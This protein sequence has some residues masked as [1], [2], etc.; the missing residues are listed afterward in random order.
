LTKLKFPDKYLPD[1]YLTER[2]LY[3]IFGIVFLFIIGF[4][5]P[6]FLPAGQIILLIL[7]IGIII[8]LSL[9]Y[10]IKTPFKAKRITEDKLSNGDFN[11]AIIQVSSDYPFT[12]LVKVADE[13]PAE[14][15]L[16]NK[17]FYLGKCKSRFKR[18]ISYEFRPISRGAYNFGDIR[19]FTSTLF[20]MIQRR[21]TI[22]A[23]IDLPVYPSFIQLRKFS[24]YAINNRLDE[25][26]VKRIRRLGSSNEF[27]QIREYVRGDDFRKINWSA[28]AR[29]RELMVNQY[30]E[31]RAQN[32]YCVID[33]GR[34]M[35][36]PFAGL[37]LI[38]Y[39]VN[40]S[41][42]LLGVAQSK[43]DKAGLL[44]FA[45]HIRVLVPAHGKA[46]QMK[47]IVDSLYNAG[48]YQEESDF[49]TLYKNVKQ[50]IRKRSLLLLFTN[51]NTLSGLK[52]QLKYLKSLSRDHLLCVIFFENTEIAELANNKAH[53]LSKAYDQTIAEKYQLEKRLIVA[54]LNKNGIY[55]ILTQP[56]DLTVN[57]INQYISFKATGA[58]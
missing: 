9:L 30:Q 53:T 28:T 33:S 38:E 29:K 49:L 3:L 55:S 52:R 1:I 15:Q 42:V 13:F 23:K 58:I 37:P 54:E 19:V 43:G 41:L 46:S 31:E 10:S 20:G 44:T 40:A 26:G 21:L 8:E 45:H 24:Y 47:R 50:K 14:L 2:A 11:I 51:F 18:D 56:Q 36:M 22:D 35:H 7:L 6:V 57:T 27:E 32:I 12:T 25:V 39:A 16:R 48:V 4:A 5:Y 34:T 17:N